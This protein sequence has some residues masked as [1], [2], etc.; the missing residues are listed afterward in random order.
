MKKPCVYDECSGHYDV[1]VFIK[2]EFVANGT[3]TEQGLSLTKGACDG[4]TDKELA[5]DLFDVV[6]GLS[7]VHIFDNNLNLR[8][9]WH[10]GA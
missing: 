4:M 6:R 1:N 7:C 10:K 8:S 2:L 9:I 3:V 5:D